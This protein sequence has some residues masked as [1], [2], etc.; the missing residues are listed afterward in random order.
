MATPFIFIQS[1]API[2]FISKKVI[3]YERDDDKDKLH[4]GMSLGEPVTPE[5]FTFVPS[6]NIRH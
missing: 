2:Q 4:P 6:K 5:A 1:E 3:H